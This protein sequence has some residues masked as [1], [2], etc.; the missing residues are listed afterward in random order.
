MWWTNWKTGVNT[1][2][3]NSTLVQ[4]VD[5]FMNSS[6]Q[7]VWQFVPG[8]DRPLCVTPT[9]DVSCVIPPPH[10]CCMAAANNGLWPYII[11]IYLA[12][13]KKSGWE[14]GLQWNRTEE[15]NQPKC[16]R[17]DVS[18]EEGR[19]AHSSGNLGRLREDPRGTRRTDGPVFLLTDRKDQETAENKSSAHLFLSCNI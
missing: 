17:E 7:F 1:P 12:R 4:F 14:L 8:V 16:P 6:C 13:Q 5:E 11:H 15:P 19:W 9:T 18:T 10:P 2:I 3:G